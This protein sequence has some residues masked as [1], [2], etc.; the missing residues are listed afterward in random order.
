M[1]SK[2]EEVDRWTDRSD[3]GGSSSEDRFTTA[4][5]KFNERNDRK[6]YKPLELDAKTLRSIHEEEV[7][8]VRSPCAADRVKFYKNVNPKVGIKLSRANVFFHR[9]DYEQLYLTE[10][11]CPISRK[12]DAEMEGVSEEELAKKSEQR[13]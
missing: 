3:D 13:E 9:M 10:G 2:T 1:E 5:A 7:F 12:P 8:I 11:H 4:L 6:Q